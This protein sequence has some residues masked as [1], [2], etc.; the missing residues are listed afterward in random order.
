MMLIPVFHD[1]YI[2]IDEEEYNKIMAN[3]K[4]G[5][6]GFGSSDIKH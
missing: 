3:S 2:D 6:K 5:D 1:E 4:R